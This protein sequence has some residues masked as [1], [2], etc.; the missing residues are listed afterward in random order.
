MSEQM[1]RGAMQ[2]NFPQAQFSNNVRGNLD[3][4]FDIAD[5]DDGKF[6]NFADLLDSALD[7]CS[8]SRQKKKSVSSAR[9]SR[10]K[11]KLS[12]PNISRKRKVCQATGDALT[13][14]EQRK[15]KWRQGTN[16]TKMK[17]AI[18]QVR[19]HG[20]SIR[21]VSEEE[22]INERALRRYVHISMDPRRQNSGYYMPCDPEEK[23]PKCLRGILWGIL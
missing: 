8:G 6:K 10:Q 17:R 2:K 21:V 4:L 13:L 14:V 1:V 7:L 20:R 18:C 9:K 11:E 15:T 12:L 5:G 22:G 16:D 3:D 19:K 23:V